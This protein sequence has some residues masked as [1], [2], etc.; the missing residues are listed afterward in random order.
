MKKPAEAGFDVAQRKQVA[1]P[2][3][4]VAGYAGRLTVL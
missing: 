2:E 1:L 3:R 4:Y